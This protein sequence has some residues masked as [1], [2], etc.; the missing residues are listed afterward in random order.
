MPLT[1]DAVQR[2][3]PDQASLSAAG[4]LRKASKWPLLG[5]RSTSDDVAA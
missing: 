2:A 4:G 1:L 5:K 3:A